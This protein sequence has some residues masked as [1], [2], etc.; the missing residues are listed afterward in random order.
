MESNNFANFPLLDEAVS[1]GSAIN[2]EVSCDELQGLSP[3]FTEHLQK[4]QRSFENYFFE[5][6]QCS[7]WVRQPFSYDTTIADIN[8]PY[9][10][11]IIEVQESEVKTLDFDTTNLQRFWCQQIESYPLIAKV[12]LGVLLS[13]VTTYL[14]EHA[15][16]ILVNFKAKKRNRFA[17]KKDRE[18]MFPRQSL[19]FHN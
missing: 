13:F 9:T 8:R 1:N 7:A 5:Q 19:E 2:D 4:L 3:V 15:F 14:R 12:A 17:Y 16:F 6:M 10:D 11:D 18:L